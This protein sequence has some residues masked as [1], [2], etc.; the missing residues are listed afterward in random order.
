M[1]GVA[2]G[3]GSAADLITQNAIEREMDLLNARYASG[4]EAQNLRTQAK[5]KR[6][7]ARGALIAGTIRAGAT[8][9]G[10]VKDANNAARL[11]KVVRMQGT[12]MPVPVPG[13]RQ[14]PSRRIGTGPM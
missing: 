4:Q 11:N 2:L 1:N 5:Q 3:T 8:V 6:S 7:A 14:V 9:L 12:T 13:G 10:G